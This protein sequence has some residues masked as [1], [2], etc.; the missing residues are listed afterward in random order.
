MKFGDQF[1]WCL[2]STWQQLSSAKHLQENTFPKHCPPPVL[3]KHIHT[4]I[5]RNPKIILEEIFLR[6]NIYEVASDFRTP[7]LTS[8]GLGICTE[9]HTQS[10]VQT[11]IW[12]L[13]E[14]SEITFHH[15][16]WPCRKFTEQRIPLFTAFL[17]SSP[18]DQ[19]A[20]KRVLPSATAALV[21][22]VG[23][24]V[25]EELLAQSQDQ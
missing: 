25:R 2:S 9:P 3:T 14:N 21:L 23:S 11:S 19:R 6:P 5:Y 24:S 10:T 16:V 4:L 15:S 1:S 8:P 17:S 12:R 18:M 13:G 20:K 22:P 7:A